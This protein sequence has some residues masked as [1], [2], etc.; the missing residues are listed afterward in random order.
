MRAIDTKN[1]SAVSLVELRERIGNS[2][3]GRTE[4]KDIVKAAE[5]YAMIDFV[6]RKFLTS[7]LQTNFSH[8]HTT[9]ASRLLRVLL[10]FPTHAAVTLS[11]TSTVLHKHSC[12]KDPVF[13]SLALRSLA[14]MS[15][16][17]ARPRGWQE[18]AA[19]A[20][21]MLLRNLRTTTLTTRPVTL[22]SPDAVSGEAR[23]LI[24]HSGL[25]G[26][27]KAWWSRRA[28]PA[29]SHLVE[30]R[31]AKSRRRLLARKQL[32]AVISETQLADIYSMEQAESV[33]VPRAKNLPS[34]KA[35]EPKLATVVVNRH[36][37]N[38]DLT[39]SST[40]SWRRMRRRL[41]APFEAATAHLPGFEY[42]I[43]KKRADKT[44]L[45]V[46]DAIDTLHVLDASFP[47]HERIIEKLGRFIVMSGISSSKQ[48]IRLLQ[49][50]PSTC[51]FLP[52]LS[53]LLRKPEIQQCFDL[54]CLVQL[55]TI[56][57]LPNDT[58]LHQ[59]LLFKA[60]QEAESSNADLVG[61]APAVAK[62]VAMSGA[63]SND[64]R[65]RR[66][67]TN[68]LLALRNCVRADAD[69]QAASTA[70]TTLGVEI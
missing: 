46:D 56:S 40:V 43:P 47:G 27:K 61:S 51:G 16:P 68:A 2:W 45:S 41:L 4:P 11:V 60:L 19:L 44:Q 55:A 20:G 49:A 5:C 62:F 9:D 3:V 67:V 8:F 30:K 6:D 39:V 54:R 34:F 21:E 29:R 65:V 48:L 25:R 66:F 13:A 10:N 35:A 26:D 12:A 52:E 33:S 7:L 50:T 32:H 42:V 28:V 15:A 24:K 31:R 58:A 70:L 64:S 59:T 36:V 69:V 18:L 57:G 38:Y 23:Q 63:G 1:I 17:A 37:R 14:A 53:S 22:R